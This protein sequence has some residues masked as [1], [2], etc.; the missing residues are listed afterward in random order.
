MMI[1]RRA[2][3]VLVFVFA[4][5]FSAV[6]GFSHAALVTWL[7][8]GVMLRETESSFDPGNVFSAKGSFVYD[9]QSHAVVDW[10]IT[11]IEHHFAPGTP[12]LA[13]TCTNT[14]NRFPG[15]FAGTD[16][17]IFAQNGISA[18]TT[19]V[20][21]LVTPE[22]TDAGGTKVLV[23][24]AGGYARGSAGAIFSEVI[25]GSLVAVPEPAVSTYLLGA[26]VLLWLSDPLR[27][28]ATQALNCK[29]GVLQLIHYSNGRSRRATIERQFQDSSSRC[30]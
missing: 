5:L 12:C 18:G 17:L 23:T 19:P 27:R 9:A 16:D 2:T 4:C 29:R 22:L 14:A 8:E 11:T 20:L 25:A 10:D 28:R 24:G 1:K 21:G 6:P 30:A 3:P 7:L 26:L 15:P 13:V